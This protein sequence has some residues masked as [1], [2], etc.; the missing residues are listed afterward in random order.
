MLPWGYRDPEHA[1][2]FLC[3]QISPGVTQAVI[4]INRESWD[5]HLKPLI[6]WTSKVSDNSSQISFKMSFSQLDPR[7]CIDVI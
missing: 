7:T 4:E 1:P 6:L 5:A 2:C 3:V